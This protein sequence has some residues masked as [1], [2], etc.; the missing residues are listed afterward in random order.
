MGI[1]YKQQKGIV[2]LE[3]ILNKPVESLLLWVMVMKVVVVFAIVGLG[4]YVLISWF[5]NTQ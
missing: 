3:V 2:M 1:T 4:A 5:K